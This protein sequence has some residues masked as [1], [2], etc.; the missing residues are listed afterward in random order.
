[1]QLTTFTDYGLRMLMYLAAQPEQQCSVREVADHYG[2]SRNHLVK[3]AH[4]L[5]QLGFIDSTK[6]R[7]GGIRLSGE[8]ASMRLGDIVL[9]LEPNM[10]IVECFDKSTNCCAITAICKAKDFFR[11]ANQ[12]FIDVLNKYT[13]SDTIVSGKSF[14]EIFA[15]PQPTN[16][17]RHKQS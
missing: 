5:S 14:L 16:P 10:H 11:Q 6:G 3:V 17:D 15:L 9:K 8:P 2:I 1:M 4:R 13:L 12:A 7:G